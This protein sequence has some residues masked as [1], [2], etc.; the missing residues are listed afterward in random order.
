[1]RQE[2]ANTLQELHAELERSPQLD[3]DAVA[4]LR[5]LMQEIQQKTSQSEDQ[6]TA[7][8]ED[9][10]PSEDSD[11]SEMLQRLQ[12]MIEDF[13]AH[14]PQLTRTLSLVAERLSDMGI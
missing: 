11:S 5:A 9:E 7:K 1:M 4:A 3:S 6:E 10:A 8:E 2:L 13:E 14:H 12:G